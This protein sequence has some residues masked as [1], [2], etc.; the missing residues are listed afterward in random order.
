MGRNKLDAKC[1]NLLRFVAYVD[2]E[3]V[4]YTTSVHASVY[5][6]IY[7][8]TIQS[9]LMDKRRVIVSILTFTEMKAVAPQSRI[10][11]NPIYFFISFAFIKFRIVFKLDNQCNFPS[12]NRLTDSSFLF[13]SPNV[14][15]ITFF[16]R[17][18]TSRY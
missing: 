6:Y 4:T 17:L 8:H 11:C 13:I 5:I 12:F 10:I 15:V 7:I 16:L 18:W 2:N 3:E 14:L 9:H 1:Q